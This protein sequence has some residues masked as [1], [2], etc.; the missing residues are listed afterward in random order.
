MSPHINEIIQYLSFFVWVIYLSIMPSEFIHFVTNEGFLH[1]MAEKY[2]SMSISISPMLICIFHIYFIN[3][4]LNS[5]LSFFHVLVILHNTAMN[6]GHRYLSLTV[7]L[8][9]LGTYPEVKLL[10]YGGSIFNFLSNFYTVLHSSSP[11]Y[12][13]TNSIQN[14]PSFHIHISIYYFLPFWW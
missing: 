3:P 8:F 9:P 10:S 1:F 5:P 2:S 11:V 14:F 4:S 7:I 6:T 13:P 12:T